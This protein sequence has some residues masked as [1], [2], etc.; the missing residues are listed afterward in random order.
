MKNKKLFFTMYSAIVL[1]LLA[2]AFVA[3]DMFNPIIWGAWFTAFGTII[4]VYNHEN[5]K[6]KKF[7]SEHFRPEL[8]GK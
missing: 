1:T 8:D 6:Q 7:I 3:K 2:I 4:A 5:V